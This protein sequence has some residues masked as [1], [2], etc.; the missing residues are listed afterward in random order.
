MLPKRGEKKDF[1]GRHLKN[2]TIVDFWAKKGNDEAMSM[3]FG[4]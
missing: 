2:D 1:L 3:K 4:Q